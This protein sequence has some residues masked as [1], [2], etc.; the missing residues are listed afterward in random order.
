MAANTV[1]GLPWYKVAIL[2][3]SQ[4]AATIVV[5]SMSQLQVAGISWRSIALYP[6]SREVEVP[7]PKDS[8]QHSSGGGTSSSL[9]PWYGGVGAL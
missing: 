6:G 2:R 1:V 3:Q 7:S 5:V 9:D 4:T 8:A